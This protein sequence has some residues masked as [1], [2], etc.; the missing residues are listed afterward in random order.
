MT[1]AKVL[2]GRQR[3]A[4]ALGDCR[5]VLGNM[6]PKS[7]DLIFGSPP[8]V[9]K[10]RRYPD[11][12]TAQK[13][14]IGEWVEWMQTVTLA[15]LRVSRCWVL[16]VANGAVRAGRYQ[17]ACEGLVW[18]LFKIGIPVERP[19]IWHKNAPP[20]R[21]GWFDN[22]WEF[23]LA[24]KSPDVD[25]PYFN[26]EAI[27]EPRDVVRV[28][29]GGGHLGSQLAHDNET[30]FPEGLPDRF[31]PVC[32]P[33]DGVV[34]DPFSGSGTTGAVALKRGRRFI[35]IE[36]RE[37]QVDLT[38]RRLREARSSGLSQKTS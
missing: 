10:G 21:H 3:S 35:G 38:R 26:W 17:P 4:V 7:V 28:P 22:D 23:I 19:C 2:D 18:E 16:W 30:P 32:C 31:V 5:T 8:Y 14:R 37:S 24:F 11:S 12:S 25:T 34:S 1:I 36:N 13:W 27:T 6:P 29:V 20:N 9:E 33:A 15:S